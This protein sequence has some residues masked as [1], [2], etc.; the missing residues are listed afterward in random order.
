MIN[1]TSHQ[2]SGNRDHSV[3]HFVRAA[4]EAIEKAD[5]SVAEDVAGSD[6]SRTASGCKR[7]GHFESGLEVPQNV[8]HRVT[9]QLCNPLLCT[10]PDNGILSGHKK[11]QST[12]T[13]YSRMGP[14]N[15]NRSRGQ[16]P[17]PHS[18]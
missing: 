2:G 6:P 13:G 16:T 10:H 1:N 4:V 18:A 12:N 3:T 5:D 15:T 8:K 14:E 7:C 11:E 17:R 9:T